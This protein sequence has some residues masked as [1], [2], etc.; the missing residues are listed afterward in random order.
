[1]SSITPVAATQYVV[2]G[3]LVLGLLFGFVGQATRFCVRGAIA[4]W[5]IFRG[6]GRLA[7]WVLAIGVGAVVVQLLMATG[8]LDAGRTLAWTP[9]LLW[10]SSLAGGLIF[11]Y[12]M[13]LA[14]G[15]PQRSLVKTGAGSLRSAVTLMVAAV[16]AMMTLRGMFAPVRVG[17]FDAF[18]VQ[19]PQS[20][21][22]GTLLAGALPVSAGAIRWLLAVALLAIAVA[23]AWRVRAA[24][25][26]HAVGGVAVGLLLGAAL[27]LTG[28]IGF[29]AE[30]PE[31]L[32][33]AWLGTQSR[34]PEGLTFAAPLA[35]LLDL[36]TL[37]TDKATVPTFGVMMVLGVLLGSFASAWTRGEVRLEV[38]ASPR[39]FG[40]HAMGGLM[41]G[42]G[43]V[44]ALGCS[45]GNG[46]TG[47]AL[48]S[49]GSILAVIGIVAGAWVALR[50][51]IRRG[52][53]AA[54]AMGAK[55]AVQR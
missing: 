37:W 42:F 29:L 19:L 11:G 39:E 33:A 12:G 30:H 51:Q 6:P 9:R 7:A 16:A 28:R 8:S 21:D 50:L 1:M 43:G 32:E 14:G 22:L 47:L 40:A 45:I 35:H 17:V 53:Q 55:V 44:T 4:D 41:M 46:V 13:V 20:Q 25:R 48:L 34:R 3:G 38:F 26:S 15:C 27:F 18:A 31:T 54:P 10:V 2:F 49:A 36:L 23:F 5:M 24:G 52:E